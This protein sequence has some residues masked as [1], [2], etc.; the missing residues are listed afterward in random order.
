MYST[1]Q[2]LSDLE[3]IGNGDFTSLNASSCETPKEK[4]ELFEH[5]FILLLS[6]FK[7]NKFDVSCQIANENVNFLCETID[8]F[9]ESNLK[10][11]VPQ[12]AFDFY[13]LTFLNATSAG[14]NHTLLIKLFQHYNKI[15]K[16]LSESSDES[17]F[18]NDRTRPSEV[19][20]SIDEARNVI[21]ARLDYL[22]EN[23]V[24]LLYSNLQHSLLL[25]F[26]SDFCLDNFTKNEITL[27]QL[28]RVALA[29]GDSQIANTFF[30]EVQDPSLQAANKGYISFYES[31]FQNAYNQFKEA[32]EAGPANP[33]ACLK[34][35]GQFSTD[36]SEQAPP[37]V[38]K[39]TPEDRTQWPM[40]PR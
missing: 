18:L 31:S 12:P 25:T 14:P 19:K 38:K 24:S 17:V 5:Q 28:G 26:I 16:I 29:C 37:K 8:N 35:L 11:E 30:N 23:I 10:N 15:K 7:E 36:P 33:D 2:F 9:Q 21:Q 27:S 32:G 20:L 1:E 4:K 40:Q 39:Q 22:A 34:Y 13:L 3:K 6:S